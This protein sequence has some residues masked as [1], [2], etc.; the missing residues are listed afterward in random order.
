MERSLSYRP[1]L[2]IFQASA[3]GKEF[4]MVD[5]MHGVCMGYIYGVVLNSS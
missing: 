2:H 5:S 3:L 4:A 1:C